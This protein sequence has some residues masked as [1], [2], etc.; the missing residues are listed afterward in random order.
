[1]STA[2]APAGVKIAP[3]KKVAT[4]GKRKK[5]IDA[6]DVKKIG[7]KDEFDPNQFYVSLT[8]HAEQ[9]G[10]EPVRIRVRRPLS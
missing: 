6:D 3:M 7:K 5:S 1:M 2:A 9:F 8:S 10:V 4:L